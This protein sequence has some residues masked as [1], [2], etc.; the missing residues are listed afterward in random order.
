ME[1][2]L[3]VQQVNPLSIIQTAVEGGADVKSLEKLMDLQER[4]E[5]GE[6][7][8]AFAES[9]ATVQR[10]IEAVVKTQENKQTSSKYADLA[11][12]I[13]MAKPVYSDNGFSVIFYEGKADL[14]EHIRVCA[15]VLHT[16]GHKESYHYDVPMDGVGI[17][18]NANMTK[19]HGKAS[20]TTYG[21]RYLMCMIWN[22]P[23]DDND[24]NVPEITE[25]IT[26][27][28]NAHISQLLS[29]RNA[30]IKR[31]TAWLVQKGVK[32]GNMQNIPDTLFEVVVARIKKN[33][34]VGK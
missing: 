15:D 26:E 30:D 31:F 12:I 1:K 3:A 28:Q 5:A 7:R 2:D 10:N 33:D 4:W 27:G 9:F 14:P 23:T 21:R 32:D 34:E 11:D 22:I 16:M 17:K 18:G 13:K 29:D 19:I 24:G 20:S 6:A 25:F 8:K